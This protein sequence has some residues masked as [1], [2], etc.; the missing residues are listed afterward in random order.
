MENNPTMIG[1][2]SSYVESTEEE[3]NEEMSQTVSE[4]P[5][6]INESL[7]SFILHLQKVSDDIANFFNP[8]ELTEAMSEEEKVAHKKK[9][10]ELESDLVEIREEFSNIYNASLYRLN[11][12]LEELNS[13]I[14]EKS[15]YEAP[16]L[17]ELNQ[18]FNNE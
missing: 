2:E 9:G 16:S 7:Q 6:E 14:Y 15:N 17:D 5:T 12:S 13:R 3:K 8:D 4:T 11:Q 18:Y 1:G 10:K